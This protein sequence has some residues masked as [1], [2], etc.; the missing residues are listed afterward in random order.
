M[1]ADLAADIGWA[2]TELE[3]IL[4]RANRRRPEADHAGDADV[5]ALPDL[6]AL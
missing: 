5:I 2:T 1:F 4:V 3:S 6:G